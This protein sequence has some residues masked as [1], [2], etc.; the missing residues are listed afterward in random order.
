[1]VSTNANEK[2]STGTRAAVALGW[3]GRTESSAEMAPH[4]QVNTTGAV[5]RWAGP[6]SG[7]VS[8]SNW[9]GT[10]TTPF[11][12]ALKSKLLVTPSMTTRPAKEPP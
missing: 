4:N 5:S 10:C 11:Q 8:V 1:M 2:H 9:A 7:S 12:T 6:L 3:T